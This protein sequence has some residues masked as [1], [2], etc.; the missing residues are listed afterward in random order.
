VL[1]GGRCQV[2]Q[3]RANRPRNR[4]LERELQIAE[5]RFV[6]EWVAPQLGA[7]DVLE[8]RVKA[9]HGTERVHHNRGD[10]VLGARLGRDA[11][12]GHRGQVL[13]VVGGLRAAGRLDGERRLGEGLV[14]Q[15]H[16][17][18]AVLVVDGSRTRHRLGVVVHVVGHSQQELDRLGHD[19]VDYREQHVAVGG[20][21]AVDHQSRRDTVPEVGAAPEVSG[22]NLAGVAVGA[23]G[24]GGCHDDCFQSLAGVLGLLRM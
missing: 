3:C 20:Q 7:E 22:A 6:T 18:L 17:D 13:E 19:R 15:R 9:I 16:R 10:R 2:L 5:G 12:D 21:V 1:R 23:T 4:S 8:Q 11:V 14:D 24:V